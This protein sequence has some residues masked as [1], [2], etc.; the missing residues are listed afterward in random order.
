MLVEILWR[1]PRLHYYQGFHDVCTCFLLV[2]GKRGAIPAAE[3]VALFFLRDAMLD[4]FD[5]VSRQLSLVTTLLSLEDP[6]LHQFLTSNNIMAF[7]TLSWV[8][9][10]YSHDITDFR[11]VVR[12]FDLFMA[13]TPLMPVYVACAIVLSRRRDL[14]VQ[15]PDMV[16]TF[17]CSLP[18]DLTIDI[19]EIVASAVELERKFPPLEVQKRSGI[20]LD[21]C[22]PVNTYDTEWHCL[23]AD[24]HPDRIAAERYLSMP[25]RKREPWEDEVAE[26]VAAMGGVVAGLVGVEPTPTES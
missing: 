14:F 6:E 21:D 2:L 5:P 18:Q 16:H 12:L 15:E 20:W 10:W 7:F 9:T 19:D 26:M 8:L 4:S 11:K 23:S 13:S 17:L 3:N 1:N 24:Q 25:P 22:S